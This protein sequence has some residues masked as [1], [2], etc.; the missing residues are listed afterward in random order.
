[1]ITAVS[2]LEYSRDPGT[3]YP[4][5]RR[6]PRPGSP[7]HGGVAGEDVIE[8]FLLQHRQRLPQP[9]QQVG[10]RRVGEE[11]RRVGR[12][13][14]V[15]VPVG[16]RQPAVLFAA[17]AFSDIALKLRPGG[18]I[19]PFCEP[20]TVTSTPQASCL[21]SIEASEMVST[22]SSAGCSARSIAATDFRMRLVTPVEVSLWTTITAL[23]VC[24][25]IG[26]KRRSI[27]RR[28]DAVPPVA[29]DKLDEQPQLSAIAVH[30]AANW[31]V[32]AISTLSPGDSVLT[33]A[34]SQAPVP[35]AGKI[36]H[37]TG[38]LENRLHA[39]QDSL[40]QRRK[41]GSA[42]IDGRHVDGAQNAIRHIGRTGDLQEVT[43]ASECH[44]TLPRF[45]TRF[46]AARCCHNYEHTR[47]F[48]PPEATTC[49]AWAGWSSPS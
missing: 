37:R 44:A 40:A 39:R 18:S 42:M 4:D 38:G 32:S 27:S 49:L 16:A 10:R 30:S 9:E 48:C 3:G 5:P 17:S 6:A 47:A 22:I 26:G 28:I 11:A 24:A 15:P 31:P 8:P 23:I 46:V 25:G 29:R 20:A 35:E 34:A 41:F 45:G 7:P 33:I 13:H 21:Y 43:A 1:M 19:R 36:D 12:E 14:V 2:T